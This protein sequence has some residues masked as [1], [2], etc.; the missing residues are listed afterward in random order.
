MSKCIQCDVELT[1]L[2]AEYY[3]LFCE[4]CEEFNHDVM[5]TEIFQYEYA[6][7][8]ESFDAFRHSRVPAREGVSC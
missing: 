2:E 6:R 8:L 3:E 5:N 7:S 4:S 1:A